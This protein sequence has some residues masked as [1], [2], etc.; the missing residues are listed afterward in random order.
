MLINRLR[1]LADNNVLRLDNALFKLGPEYRPFPLDQE[2]FDNEPL[3]LIIGEHPSEYALSPIMWNAEFR[4]RG[5]QE[6]FLPIDIPAAKKENLLSLLELAFKVGNRHFRVLTI[7]NPHKI[8]A[9]DYFRQK[10]AEFPKRVAISDDAL[11]IGATNQVLIGPDDIFHVINSDGRG[12]A[13]TVENLL[14]AKAAGKLAGKKIGIIGSGGAARG[15]IYEIAK[16]V[17]EG[18]DGSVQIFNRTVAKAE[19]L[20]EEFS[21]YFP[22]LKLS[23][24]PLADLPI[25]AKSCELLISSITSGDPL[26][27]QS[28]YIHLPKGMLLIDANYGANSVLKQNATV[29]G[30]NDLDIHDGSGMVVEGYIIPS[31]ELAKLWGYEV[32]S[33]VYRKIGRLFGYRPINT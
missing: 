9:L 25:Q 29:A 13:N 7:T 3:S 22:D 18:K 2:R 23:A 8:D 15:I 10:Q 16:R 14:E 20:A 32:P 31:Q 19:E 17:H 6:L 27:E 11:R 5:S 21:A 24:K 4:L 1:L 28:V 26:S 12:M 30:R 33:D